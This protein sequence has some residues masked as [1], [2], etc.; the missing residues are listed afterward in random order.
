MAKRSFGKTILAGCYVFCI[1]LGFLLGIIGWCVQYAADS[2]EEFVVC[3]AIVFL[4]GLILFGVWMMSPC[5]RRNNAN[6]LRSAVLVAITWNVFGLLYATLFTVILQQYPLGFSIPYT[7][8]I[9]YLQLCIFVEFLLLSQCKMPT[10]TTRIAIGWP[11]G[12][13]FSAISISGFLLVIFP[14][15]TWVNY[16]SILFVI[17]L[18]LSC[19]GL[20][21]TTYTPNDIGNWDL[22]EVDGPDGYVA[23]DTPKRVKYNRSKFGSL[24]QHSDQKKL[25]IVQISDPHLGTMMSVE[26][27]EQICQQAVD[28]DPDIIF[29]TGDFFTVEAYDQDENALVRALNPLRPVANRTFCCIGN[30]DKEHCA[31]ERL[32]FALQDIGIE[33]LVGDEATIDTAKGLVQIIGLDFHYP[34]D[35]QRTPHIE[36]VLSKYPARNEQV[37]RVVL[38]HDPGAF[39]IIPSYDRCLVLSGHTHGGQMGFVS[40]GLNLTLISLAGIPDQG[41]WELGMNRLYVNRAQGCRSILGTMLVRLGCPPEFS[42]MHITLPRD[43]ALK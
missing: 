12:I 14:L 33:F 30:H 26:R 15:M 5:A 18:L 24:A 37:L 17:P 9:S 40:L 29:L 1:L 39:H 21:Q 41:L 38:L 35:P 43:S 25:R 31:R 19:V 13:M 3:E 22:V 36:S 7:V 10:L 27:L 42:V 4:F 2:W 8:V 28:S 23:G 20:Y 6:G 16:C 34:I 32:E 11:A